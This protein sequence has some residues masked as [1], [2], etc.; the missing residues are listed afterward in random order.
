MAAS[1]VLPNVPSYRSESSADLSDPATRRRLSP[2]AVK[3]FLAIME[4]WSLRDPEARELLGGMSTGSFY[5]LK[6]EPRT[7]DQDRLTRI[8]LIVGIFKAL[9]ILYSPKLADAWVKL[10]NS[11][12]IFRGLT[13]VAYM[14]QRGQPG[15]LSVRQLLDARRGGQ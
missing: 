3:G 1:L 4:K 2:A 5:A 8:S 14:I 6:K 7:L 13:P 15:M 11:N 10:P 12:P 9:N